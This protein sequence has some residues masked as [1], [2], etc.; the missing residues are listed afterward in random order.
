MNPR[1]YWEDCGNN[2]HINIGVSQIEPVQ[3]HRIDLAGIW[4]K[5]IQ[6]I[7]RFAVEALDKNL[8]KSNQNRELDQ[9]R[10]ART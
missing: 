10:Q 4:Y 6:P 9:K 1:K 7:E 2:R 5:V 8:V 3:K